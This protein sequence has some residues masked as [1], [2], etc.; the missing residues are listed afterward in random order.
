MSSS[1]CIR[2]VIVQPICTL[3]RTS[4]YSSNTYTSNKPSKRYASSQTQQLQRRTSNYIDNNV[5]NNN[6][7]VNIQ[8]SLPNNS[9]IDDVDKPN[10]SNL[11]RQLHDLF[12]NNQYL[13]MLRMY[14]D[15]IKPNNE[16]IL[17]NLQWLC[18]LKACRNKRP[19]RLLTLLYEMREI[20]HK[21]PD[22]FKITQP[23]A[24]NIVL[25]HIT[26]PQHLDTRA[27]SQLY[28]LMITDG[29]QPDHVTYVCLIRCY[30]YYNNRNVDLVKALWS[31]CYNNKVHTKMMYTELSSVF[32][33]LYKC[34]LYEMCE[35]VY[36]IMLELNFSP[37][38]FVLVSLYQTYINRNKLQ[39]AD[40]L[41]NRFYTRYNGGSTDKKLSTVSYTIDVIKA[42]QQ[43]DIDKIIQLTKKVIVEDENYDRAIAGHALDAMIKLKSSK[44]AK[45]IWNLLIDTQY[46]KNNKIQYRKYKNDKNN[47]NTY[48]DNDIVHDDETDDVNADYNTVFNEDD[49]IPLATVYSQ[50]IECL[51]NACTDRTQDETLQDSQYV[52]TLIYDMKKHNLQ[53][54]YSAAHR[55]VHRLN[56][57]D[58]P[59][60]TGLYD[61]YTW[62]IQQ[63]KGNR[64]WLYREMIVAYMK[65]HEY[66]KA[67]NIVND[68][69]QAEK[70]G[71]SVWNYSLYSIVVILYVQI[72]DTQNAEYYFNKCKEH[73]F[74]PNA[75]LYSEIILTYARD[76]HDGITALYYIN[77]FTQESIAQQEKKNKIK[78]NN[79]NNNNNSNLT[80]L[81]LLNKNLSNHKKN[82]HTL[83]RQSIHYTVLALYYKQQYQKVIDL[84]IEVVD[85]NINLPH[86]SYHTIIKSITELAKNGLLILYN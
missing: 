59:D 20:S 76:K 39:Q 78:I 30:A 85:A 22:L 63:N 11:T 6:D 47:N 72:R 7:N 40:D 19:D 48:N 3:C 26:A 77:E 14:D 23:N 41:V 60:L 38:Q 82:L 45:T 36:G 54:S 5:Y 21:H 55:I 83:D 43:G 8:Q 73:G 81:M 86:G 29:I 64:E 37:N 70:Q 84:Y 2:H 50:L 53:I 15:Y 71:H 69:V 66:D 65:Y 4:L 80:T 18:I 74:K 56:R 68:A 61:L 28:Q 62:L 16:Y 35:Q 32:E 57:V 24:Y 10:W 9:T 49:N 51:S 79:K 34:E 33:S 25:L 44:G 27:A 13:R 31:E 42:E 58:K 46:Y 17:D 67:I 75:M 12:D 52:K 1:P